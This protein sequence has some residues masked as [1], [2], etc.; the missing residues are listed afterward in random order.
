MRKLFF[1]AWL[2]VTVFGSGHSP[3]APATVASAVTCALLWFLPFLLRWPLALMLIPV[4]YLGVRL[5]DRAIGAFEVI[6][7]ERFASLR[8]PDPK[9]EDPDQVVIDEFCG[10]WIT[11][12]AVPHTLAGFAVAFVVF[13]VL[14]ILKPLG[15]SKSQ[16]ARG[17]WGVM[18]DDLLAGAL[19]AVLLTLMT[20]LAGDYLPEWYYRG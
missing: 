9:R 5:S 3:V 1:P 7:D 2:A 17:G 12:L 8:R 15:I 18:I 14:D 4:T 6:S 11:L 20:V 13:R 10:Q 16:N 19:G